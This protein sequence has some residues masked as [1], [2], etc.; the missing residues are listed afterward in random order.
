M[1]ANVFDEN[2]DDADECEASG[3]GYPQHIKVVDSKVEKF[4]VEYGSSN[5][6]ACWVGDYTVYATFTAP[7]SREIANR[8]VD[9]TVTGYNGNEHK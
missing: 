8:E 4:T 1:L 2:G 7:D 3:M 9:F 6:A 5:W